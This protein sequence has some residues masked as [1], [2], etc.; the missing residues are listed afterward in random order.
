MAFAQAPQ[1]AALL[2][3][4]EPLAALRRA[5]APLPP[6]VLASASPFRLAVLEAAGVTPAAVVKP[7]I[8]EKAIRRDTP[9]ELVQAL[10]HAKADAALAKV[11]TALAGRQTQQVMKGCHHARLRRGLV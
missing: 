3:A 8:D 10:A 4:L 6:L 7:D 9:R 2:R 11:G 5:A 1:A